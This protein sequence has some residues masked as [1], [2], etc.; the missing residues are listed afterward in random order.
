MKQHL[1]A[2]QPCLIFPLF[3]FVLLLSFV[4][5]FLVRHNWGDE[6]R[7]ALYTNNERH[8]ELTNEWESA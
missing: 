7:H 6:G 8:L 4:R 1:L 2:R 5:F 3:L